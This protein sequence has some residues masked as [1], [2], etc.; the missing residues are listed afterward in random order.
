GEELD[1][2]GRCQALERRED[3]GSELHGLLE[4]TARHRK[5][6]AEA[7]VPLQ[8]PREH[9]RGG[10]V[11]AVGD[12]AEELAISGVVEIPVLGAAVEIVVAPQPPG[13]M[14]LK[15]QTAGNHRLAGHSRINSR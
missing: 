5:G 12:S 8:Q 14:D 13:L 2:P 7:V 4:N 3:L 15:I 11:A 6:D 1:A 9:G 10:K